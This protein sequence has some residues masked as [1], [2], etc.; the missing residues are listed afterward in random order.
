MAVAVKGALSTV[1]FDADGAGAGV[2]AELEKGSTY[3]FTRETKT[4][5]HGPYFGDPTIEEVAAGN[6]YNWKIDG[7]V[8]EGN[9]AALDAM[10]IYQEAQSTAGTLVMYTVKGKQITMTNVLITKYTVKGEAKG[11][12]TISVEGSA[13]AAVTTA[14]PLS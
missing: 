14:A 7:D 12:Q 5:E 10:D 3:E 2:V 8:P 13:K 9:D 6:K 11:T 4:D 1:S